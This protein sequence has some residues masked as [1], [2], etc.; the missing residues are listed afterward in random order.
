[1]KKYSKKI[2]V[3]LVVIVF[4]IG[5]ITFINPYKNK[6]SNKEYYSYVDINNNEIVY[7]SDLDYITE[8]NWSYN[9]WAGHNIEKDKNPE[10]G[11]ISLLVD[12]AKKIFVKGVGVHANGQVTYDISS[13]SSQYSRFVAWVGVD[14][15]R[16]TNGSVKFNFYVSN[17]GEN[18]TSLQVTDVLKGNT[19]SVSVDLNIAGYKYFRVFVDR[20]I[21]GNT[22]DHGVIADAK[23]VKDDYQHS[24]IEYDNLK[25]ISYY[26]EILQ[27]KDANYNMENNYDLILK[28]EFVRKIGYSEIE[29]LV[30]YLPR[31]KDTLDWILSDTNRIEEVIEVGE[32]NGV[33]FIKTLTDLYEAN[34]NILSSSDG[35]VYQ[36]M[37]IGLAAAYSTDK[38]ASALQFGHKNADYDYLE[39]F[40]IYKELYD[41]DLMT[42]YK[43]YFKN[44]SVQL[45]RLVMS[46][47]ARNDE[48]KWLN[49]YTRL[50]DNNQSVYKYVRHTGTGVGYNDTEF[51]SAEYEQKYE[52]LYH[53]AVY[54][55]PFA[56][57]YQRYWMVINKGG[58]C[59]NQSRVFQSLFNSI[60]S[61]TIGVYQPSHEATF[62]YLANSDGTGRWN[63]ANNIFGWQKS[64]TSWYGGNIYRTILGWGNKSFANQ[65]ISGNN[66]GNSGSYV[67]LEQE[68]INDYD[69]YQKSLYWNLLANSY[70]DNDKK[71]DIYNK[72]LEINNINLDSYD[73]LINV[74]K[75]VDKSVDEWYD[76]ALRVIDSYT[77]YPM[78]MNDLLKII[79]PYLENEKRVDIDLKEYNALNISAKATSSD[80]MHD[81]AARDIAKE[82]LG[83][84]NAK[85]ATFSFDGDN[86]N[87][88]VLNEQYKDYD[89]AWRYSLDGGQTKSQA[90]LKKS[91]EL[92]KDEIN[93]ITE[94]NDILI[95][96]DGLD[97]NTPTYTIDI[98]KSSV[99]T[100]LYNN[101]L[102]NK[103]IGVSATMEWR[104]TDND[105]WTSYR[106]E[107]PDLTGDKSVQV[108]FGAYQNYLPS[109]Y[110]TFDF[111]EDVVDLKRKYIPISYLTIHKVS[112]EAVNN[113]GSA[114]FAI[115][116]N[117][118]TRWHSNWNGKDTERYI[119]VKLSRAVHL[120]AIEFVPA[121]GGNGRIIDGLVE[122]SMDGEN[123]FN[124][125][126]VKNL[127]YGSNYN[128]YNFGKNNIKNIETDATDEVMYVR[129]TATKASNGNWFAARMF[130]FYQ[131]A[132][133]AE[134]PTAGISYSTTEI[135]N[136]DVVASL[137]DYEDDKVKLI[138]GN[139]YTFTK[140][141]EHKF[142]I[143]D[144]FT[145]KRS[146]IIAKVDWIDKEKP[147]G[148]ITYDIENKTNKT[149]MATLVVNEDVT[150]LNNT[151]FSINSDGKIVNAA[152]EI[153]NG[154]TV[155]NKNNVYD[156]NGNYIANMNPFVY[157]FIDNG[158]FKFEFVD[159]AGNKNVAT[160]KVDWIDKEA[161]V[162]SLE[163]D[164]NNLTNKDVTVKISF[165]K[166]NVKILNNDGKDYYVFDKNGEFTFK[167][168]DEA[169]NE[170]SI[171][172]KV[173]WIDKEVP[174]ASVKIDK[175]NKSLAIVKIVNPSK[176][177]VFDVGT[178]I[179]EF[180]KNG[181]YDIV[182][183]DK[184]GNKGVITVVIDW[185]EE[186]KNN[187]NEVKKDDVVSG[188]DSKKDNSSKTDN[189][190]DNVN[191][192]N[193]DNKD[194][195]NKPDDKDDVIKPDDNDNKP[196]DSKKDEIKSDNVQ[197]ETKNEY[198]II[199]LVVTVVG[200]SS[201][202]FVIILKIRKK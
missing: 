83:K 91:Y 149:V 132:T 160:A 69:K 53:L 121:G 78:A 104:Y 118:N 112:S 110:L 192:P 47:G 85:T 26:D 175:S 59:W 2:S 116:G 148:Y 1:M 62:Y 60:G 197:K 147:I 190:K 167:Y 96:I 27:S 165:N 105:D 17:D 161:P 143:E 75:N 178:G 119:T 146:S 9:G 184:L 191:K 51:H 44:Y 58:I 64:G 22:A 89:L 25:D 3:L 163:Y 130:N 168:V 61:P 76:L 109:D 173:N 31:Y 126:E 200:L 139:T 98:V 43:N 145:G 70:S 180:T 174:T 86:K 72:A 21:N 117:Y 100:N 142:V 156:K 67:Y 122:G 188:D 128:D 54:N 79:K 49:Y 8:N 65:M 28:R 193:T 32:V 46:D 189:R 5:V 63:I 37:I 123:W 81:G 131:D 73:Y 92:S 95:Y 93:S 199:P 6:S 187:D 50:N 106:E 20:S 198:N 166:D 18:W 11:T 94:D 84:T 129:I 194:D 162:A 52:D 10:G 34:K 113:Q 56:D 71:M 172:A 36:K 88:I 80:V 157:E 68:N 171:N 90:I 66:A 13:L 158:E 201:V 159:K 151:N 185:L 186:N 23:F 115:D 16:G 137:V 14:A 127:T 196:S 99:P 176:D 82:L 152:W 150:V 57:G 120:S 30:N 134:G 144:I 107:M 38:V 40:E 45:M 87:K 202:I 182:F 24:L 114:I 7:M 169:G 141:G 4:V 183:Y 103:V 55:V 125:A 195:T 155:D 181:T 177:I 102:E 179:Y 138:N 39:R 136:K 101:D 154:Y 41:N 77:Y 12:G 74:Y 164:I 29:A 42:I 133:L 153:M 108:R 48:I 135:T 15:S 124:L 111:T 35:H 19:N 170:G 33:P 140:N 97:V